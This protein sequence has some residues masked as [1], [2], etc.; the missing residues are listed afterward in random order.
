MKIGDKEWQRI[1]TNFIEDDPRMAEMV[2][3]DPDLPAIS[4]AEWS[5]LCFMKDEIEREVE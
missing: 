1:K 3:I 5:M 4:T 2:S